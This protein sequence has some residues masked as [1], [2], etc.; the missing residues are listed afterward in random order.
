MIDVDL[1]TKVNEPVLDANT[2]YDQWLAE[3]RIHSGSVFEMTK[4]L[5]QSLENGYVPWSV[6]ALIRYDV[7]K[8]SQCDLLHKIVKGLYKELAADKKFD[9]AKATREF[10]EWGEKLED[11]KKYDSLHPGSKTFDAVEMEHH[12]WLAYN[13]IEVKYKDELH[14]VPRGTGVLK[15][16]VQFGPDPEDVPRWMSMLKEIE[17]YAME[18]YRIPIPKVLGPVSPTNP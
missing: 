18:Y 7:E 10:T 2:I 13:T 5:N 1:E 8:G 17:E 4:L 6:P 3:G 14:Y 16:S 9:S 15:D 12:L 11:A